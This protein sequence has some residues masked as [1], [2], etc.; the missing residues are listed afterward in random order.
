MGSRTQYVLCRDAVELLLLP[1]GL[2]KG[3]NKSGRR[4]CTPLKMALASGQGQ[5]SGS[6]GAWQSNF[7]LSSLLVLDWISM[8]FP[9]A[10]EGFLSVLYCG[11]QRPRV[12]SRN[13]LEVSQLTSVHSDK[14]ERL[15]NPQ[16]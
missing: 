4:Y 14:Q 16:K 9:V 6:K 2:R 13:H 11:V 10:T 12:S 1:F 5:M 7:A 15:S 8:K 3:R